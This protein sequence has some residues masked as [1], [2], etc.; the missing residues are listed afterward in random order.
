MA[1]GGKETPRQAMIGM[2]YLV[3]TALLA[4]QVSNAV[5]DKF[6]FIDQS[7]KQS[8]MSAGRNNDGRVSAIEQ[9]VDKRGKKARDLE[10][11]KKAKLAQAETQEMVNY[12][13]GVRA[14]IVE[15]SGGIDEETKKLNGAKDYDKQM[16]Y[17]LGVE[18]KKNGEAYTMKTKLNDFVKKINALHED[19]NLSPLA[20]DAKEIEIFKNDP[21]QKQKDFAQLNFDHTPAVACL[22]II[23]Q[24]QTEVTNAGSKALEVLAGEVGAD[25]L[26]FDKIMAVVSP[27]SKVVAAG[28]KYRA[29]M[30]LAASSSTTKPTMTYNGKAVKVE[31]GKGIIE[32]TANA[33]SY[34]KENKSVQ[35][36]KGSITI[37]APTGDTTLQI[38][39]EFIVAKPV[40]QVQSGSVQALYMNCGNV[41]QINVPALGNA[42]APSFSASGASVIKG[43]K[44]GAVTVVPDK[45]KVSLTVSSGGNKIGTESFNVKRVPKPTI[46]LLSRGKAVDLKNGVNASGMPRS[47]TAK[48]I[49]DEDF[50]AFLPK[51]A[52]YRVTNW[53]ISHARGRRAIGVKKGSSETVDINDFAAKAKPGD[54]IVIEIKKV[55]R[56]NFQ[57]KVEDVKGVSEIITIPIN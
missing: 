9:Q 48:S 1:G 45:G 28:T 37:E 22:A 12:L 32:F 39:E 20:L 13:E 5:L 57:N 51:D 8:V 46:K 23:S 40:I 43:A 17:T 24:L 7:L 50:A 19:L 27:E 33:G 4:L 35:K 47:L 21:D 44:K 25:E 16:L 2:M 54:R 41:L 38:E 52:R 6:I 55:A 56:M 36:W 42:Y 34:D 31:N 18:G 11:L 29:E 49:P 15:V 30:F 53:E 3:L 26:R 10:V 14:K